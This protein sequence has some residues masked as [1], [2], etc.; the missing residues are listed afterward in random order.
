MEKTLIFKGVATAL[1]TPFRNGAID[2]DALRRIIDLQIDSG[3][4]AL[5]IGGTTGEAAVLSPRERCELYVKACEITDGRAR[6]IA[7]VGTNDTRTTIEYAEMARS[8]GANALLAVTPY[9]NKGTNDGLVYHYLSLANSTDLPIILYNVP[10]RTGVNLPIE[11]ID[12][13][14]HNERISAIK[15]ATDSLDRL[16]ALSALAERITLYSGNDSQIYPTLSLGG[17]G[18]ISVA[19]N[20]IPTLIKRIC[21]EYFSGNLR[22]A[23]MLQRRV[24]RLVN[25][26]FTETNPSPI[27][28]LMNALGYCS[29]E[30]RLPLSEADEKTREL[31]LDEYRR[32]VN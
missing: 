13:L 29:G 23:L 5:V 16:T 19:S 18:I 31:V 14:S 22:E 15:E 1:I 25:S 24:L 10:S 4:E 27:K 8:A 20:A 2:F 21:D 3:I 7:G 30:I 26:L 32:L 12:K 9:Y 17:M 28:A 6:V 11:T